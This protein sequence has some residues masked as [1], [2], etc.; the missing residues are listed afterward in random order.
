MA[1]LKSIFFTRKS[2]AFDLLTTCSVHVVSQ[3][4]AHD[5]GLE[6]DPEAEEFWHISDLARSRLKRRGSGITTMRHLL[7]ARTYAQI[8]PQ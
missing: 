3:G 4:R 1:T 6:N 8:L 7:F 5:V 2:G